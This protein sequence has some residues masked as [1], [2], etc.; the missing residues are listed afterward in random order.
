MLS[1][2]QIELAGIDS[3][4]C[5]MGQMPVARNMFVLLAKVR[6]ARHSRHRSTY[7]WVWSEG[8]HEEA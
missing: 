7:A 6:G 2:I 4:V 1:K 5:I 3:N 8:K